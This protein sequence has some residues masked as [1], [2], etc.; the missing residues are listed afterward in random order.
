MR[1]IS[2]LCLIL[3]FACSSK[4]TQYHKFEKKEGGYSD[5]RA[6]DDL[7][8]TKFEGNSL[9]KKSYAE[10]FARFHSMEECKKRG[11]PISHIL[12]VIDKSSTKKVIR[13]YGDAWGPTYYSGYGMYP[14]N[15]WYG[16]SGVSI[17]MTTVNSSAWEETLVYPEIDVIFH[18]TEKVYEPEI[19]MRDI[20]ADEMK[21]LVKD[22]K[23]GIQV[24]KILPGSPNKMLKEE[25]IIIKAGGKRIMKGHQLLAFF[26]DKPATVK[27]EVLREGVRKTIPLKAEE[28]TSQ[29]EKNLSEL[30]SS[31]CKF[32]D[33][34]T[35]SSLCKENI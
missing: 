18:C 32:E 5:A 26:K 23:G 24:E 15:S 29:V 30:K 27:V 13:S 31:A 3:L 12:G 7:L 9:T 6:E 28:V 1:L 34:K 22:L 33:V 2:I 19:T 14:Y 21:H 11:K 8:V 10:T 35:A 25:D 20:P 17:G 4:R 16:G